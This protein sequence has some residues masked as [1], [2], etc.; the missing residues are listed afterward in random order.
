MTLHRLPVLSK[1]SGAEPYGYGGSLHV[2]YLY[3]CEGC[4]ILTGEKGI[5]STRM[6]VELAVVFGFGKDATDSVKEFVARRDRRMRLNLV[7]GLAPDQNLSG[8]ESD[9]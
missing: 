9:N 8:S 6:V 3:P 1:D 5:Q 7:C 2:L 4:G